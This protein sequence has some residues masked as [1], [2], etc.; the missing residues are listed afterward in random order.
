M[1]TLEEENAILARQVAYFASDDRIKERAALWHDATPQELLESLD[2]L[3]HEGDLMLDAMEPATRARSL[4]FAAR[5]LPD[6]TLA[7]LEALWR[8]RPRAR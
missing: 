3:C 2:G 4:A 7:I 1:A 5:P 6:D 8:N